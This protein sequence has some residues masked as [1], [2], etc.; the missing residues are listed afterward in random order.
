MFRNH[1]TPWHIFITADKLRL[2]KLSQST[3]HVTSNCCPPN[4]V[5]YH[6]TSTSMCLNF[7]RCYW[8]TLCPPS[9]GQLKWQARCYMPAVA[10]CRLMQVTEQLG[11]A[12]ARPIQFFGCC[13]R[14]SSGDWL[15][16]VHRGRNITSP[17]RLW[18]CTIPLCEMWGKWPW[19]LTSMNW[20]HHLN[21]AFW[22][23]K[24]WKL[25]GIL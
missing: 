13:E 6:V 23:W 7:F 21:A 8:L 19:R 16:S 24:E 9:A 22:K 25:G 4:N 18:G 12:S 20:P 10:K 11:S 14:P 1:A 2:N 17:H 5:E 3:T 15:Q